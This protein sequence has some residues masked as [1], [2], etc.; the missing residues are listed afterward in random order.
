MNS[1]TKITVALDGTGGDNVDAKTV[2]SAVRFALV[3]YPNIRI[4]VYGSQKLKVA[5]A[6]EKIDSS[7]YEFIDAPECIPQDEDPRAVLEGYRTSAM[8]RVIEAVKDKEADVAVSSGGTGPLVSLS[9]HI[10][11]TI[12]GLRPALCAKIPAGPAKYSLMLDLGANASSNAKDLHDFAI[13]GQTAYQCFYNVSK[14]RV[15]VL[16]VGSERNKGSALVKEARDLIEQDHSLNC[17]GFVEADKLFTDDA[18]VIVTDG[19]T[20]NVALKAAEGV[21]SAFLNAQGMKKFFSKLARPEWLQPW[22]YN[23]SVLLGVDGLVI[24][25]HASAGKEAVAVALVEAAKTAQL[26]LVETIKKQVQ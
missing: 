23:G 9:R 26:N 14:P 22:Q 1:E 20:G 10:L 13:L 21:A 24:K 12:G 3:L 8:R 15:C 2:A 11:G 4:K 25:S 16:N 17:Y 18:D 19:F 6:F 7:R 5:L